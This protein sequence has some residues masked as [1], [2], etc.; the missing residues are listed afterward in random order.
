M[1]GH[2]LGRRTLLGGGLLLGLG[3]AV[4]QLWGHR[5]MEPADSPFLGASARTT[6]VA[7]LSAL[8]PEDAPHAEV[9]DEIDRFL[10]AGDPVVGGQL[11]LALGALEHLGGSGPLAFSRFSRRSRTE[12]TE[13]LEGWR[14]SA[15]GPKRRIGDALR[16]VALFG[17]YARPSTWEAIGYDGPWV[18]R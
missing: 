3:W 14:L 11:V 6:L 8:L 13:V 9:A 18:G 16:R 5:P 10:A 2:P 12:R 1:Q 4:G 7:V 15:F 17:W